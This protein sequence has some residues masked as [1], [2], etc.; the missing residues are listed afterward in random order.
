MLFSEGSFFRRHKIVKRGL[1][2]FLLLVLLLVVFIGY[3]MKGP[4]R[5]YKVDFLKVGEGTKPGAL[6]SVSVFP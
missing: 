2:L 5:S 3:R 6:R 4:Y 1:G